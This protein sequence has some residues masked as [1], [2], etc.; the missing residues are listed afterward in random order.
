MISLRNEPDT[1]EAPPFFEQ[2]PKLTEKI[3]SQ[4]GWLTGAMGMEHRPQQEDM[5][6]SVAQHLLDDSPLLFEAGTGVGKSLAYLLPGI[7]MSL[8]TRRPFIISSNT[9]SLQEQVL[10]KDIPLCS[11]FFAKVP[12][13][14]KYKK[15]E[16][17]LLVGKGNYLCPN[18]LAAAIRAKTELFPSENLSELGRIADWAKE[19]KH[20]MRQEL[21]PAPTTEIWTQVNADSSTCSRKNCNASHCHY[22]KAKARIQKANVLILNHSLL[23]ALLGA[24]MHPEGKT[25]G[26]LY[27]Q[28]FMVLDE[29]HRIPAI[30]TEH[31]GLDI[32][33]YG[34]G[35]ALKLLYNPKRKRGLFTKVGTP[36]DCQMVTDAIRSSEGFFHYVRDAYLMERPIT[37]LMEPAAGDLDSLHPIYYL[38]QRIATIAENLSNERVIDELKDHRDKILN[39]YHNIHEFWRMDKKDHVHWFERGGRKGIITHL[40][41][42][43]VDVAPYLRK[44]IFSRNTG[45]ILTS[46]TLSISGCMDNFQKAAGAEEQPS[47]IRDSPFNYQDKV[48]AF[49]A[50][51]SPDPLPQGEKDQL[52]KFLAENIEYFTSNIK[53]GSLVLFNSY[54]DLYAV[55]DIL[56]ESILI[57]NRPLFIQGRELSRTKALRQFSNAGNGLLL[58]TDTFWTGVDVPG[59]SLS[60]V[61]VTRLPFENPTHPI[62]QARQEWLRAEGRNPF[63]ELTLP[64]AII[65]FRQGIGRLIRNKEDQGILTILDSRVLRKNYGLHFL[66]ALPVQHR[67]FNSQSRPNLR[68]FGI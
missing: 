58:G 54:K 39:Y 7:M 37:R 10:Q 43:P 31:F 63:L 49:I 33:S 24:G 26:V 19:T 3:F 18:R 32:S 64:D 45:V 2:L 17:A 34:L 48:K 56:S 8:E 65:K 57:K 23:F 62:A 12:E 5:A 27:P 60:Q 59:P 20:G 55:A 22:Q 47:V 13:L 53:G 67:N 51:D 21:S 9:I 61:I 38:T 50:E 29:A 11:R 52:V 42:A 15:F 66:N 44:H 36:K 14:E 41:T 16:T 1:P 35:L 28:D 46:A 68:E 25:S 4:S 6:S 30:A 40:K